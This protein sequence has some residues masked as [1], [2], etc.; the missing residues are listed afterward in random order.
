[1]AS[2]HWSSHQCFFFDFIQGVTDRFPQLF[3]KET[4]GDDEDDKPAWTKGVAEY[5]L[6]GWGWYPV[7]WRLS[8]EDATKIEPVL[9]LGYDLVLTTASYL[10]D[11]GK[12]EQAKYEAM[13]HS[14]KK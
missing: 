9:K 5:D 2:H 13:R 8:G 12:A 14:R 4:E 6:S 10:A 7:V 3:K 11:V 1:M